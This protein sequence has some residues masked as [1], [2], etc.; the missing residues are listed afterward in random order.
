MNRNSYY[1]VS[2]AVYSLHHSQTVSQIPGVFCS[3]D[4][5]I[6]MPASGK[7]TPVSSASS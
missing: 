6:S 4:P 3:L 2:H 1:E 5:V 7:R